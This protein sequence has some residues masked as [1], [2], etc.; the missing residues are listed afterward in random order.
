[1]TV[2][3]RN[4]GLQADVRPYAHN[5]DGAACCVIG[6]IGYPLVIQGNKQLFICLDAVIG[7]YH[8]LWLVAKLTVANKGRHATVLQI[9]NLRG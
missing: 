8:L 5:I 3:M 2:L 4:D 6:G 1:M 7:F 9:A